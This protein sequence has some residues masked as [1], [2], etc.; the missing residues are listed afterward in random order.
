MSKLAA[1]ISP[2]ATFPLASD[3]ASL[4]V[5]VPMASKIIVPIDAAQAK[6]PALY[7]EAVAA[8][9][10]CDRIDECQHWSNKA[11]AIGAYAK[12]AGD[13]TLRA[14]ADRIKARSVRRMGELL[15]EHNAPGKRTDKPTEGDHG[16]LSQREVAERAGVSEHRQLQAVRVANV[17]A[18]Q[19]ETAI[20]RKRPMTV[21]QLADKGK[22]SRSKPAA[23]VIRT[24][25][26]I[27]I[28]TPLR[29]ASAYNTRLMNFIDSYY[30]EVKA[31]SDNTALDKETKA[32]LVDAIERGAMRLYDLRRALD[33]ENVGPEQPRDR[34]RL[35]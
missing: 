4:P 10:E 23:G 3:G 5:S 29:Q 11:E 25:S 20:E 15:K 19:F 2:E 31:W 17:P 33:G 21:A 13:D 34:K 6:L 30:R 32:C 28:I 24:A 26:G 1:T 12:M 7:E 9:A 27:T 16:K 14:M 8:L 35:R 18:K 22:T